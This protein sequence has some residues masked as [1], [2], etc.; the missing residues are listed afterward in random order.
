MDKNDHSRRMRPQATYKV[1]Y[2]TQGGAPR[3][4][5]RPSV[6]EDAMRTQLTALQRSGVAL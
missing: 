3:P 4:N 6:L 1:G 2:G 5:S